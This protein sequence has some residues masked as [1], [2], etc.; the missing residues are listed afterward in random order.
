MGKLAQ[1]TNKY[2]IYTKIEADGVLEKPD[3]IGAIFGQTEGLLGPDMDLRELQRT[4]RIGRIEVDIKTNNGKSYGSIKIPSSLSA[5]ET[6]LIGATLETIERIGP[7]EA[8]LITEKIEDIRS[9]KRKFL[10][11]R[12]KEILSQVFEEAMPETQEITE[13]IK[14]AVR[15]S[16]MTN[17]K[18]HPAG[19]NLQSYDSVIICEGRADVSNLLSKGIKNT[20]A[21]E[22][23][24]VSDSI[25]GL[26]KEKLTTAFVDGDRGGDL[27]LKELFQK[28][29]EL[30]FII[31][32]PEGKEVEDLTKKEIFKSLREKI[33]ADQLK[34]KYTGEVRRKRRRGKKGGYEKKIKLSEKEKKLKGVLDE[35]TATRAAYLFD[36]EMNILGKVP[37][38]EMFNAMKDVDAESLVF[39]GIVDQKLVNFASNRGVKYI[40]GMRSTEK[41]RV[42]KG[43][44][45][46]VP[47]KK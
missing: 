13:Q 31:K 16:E 39:D 37:T 36:K 33:P 42:P 7:C 23:T 5:S 20:I 6:A 46:I 12:A 8:K 18:G 30:D 26:S 3:V 15:V 2:T 34:Q 11:N 29:A 41:I 44:K 27:I 45:M 14:E 25:I 9:T 21:I 35:L 43:V 10:V 22:G 38:K 28:G 19:S 40:V 4:G 32:A 24:S 17:Y 47:Q 1:S